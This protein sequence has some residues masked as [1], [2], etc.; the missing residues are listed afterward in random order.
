[1]LDSPQYMNADY[2]LP[3]IEALCPNPE[4][5]T[6][7][8]FLECLLLELTKE[9]SANKNL[10]EQFRIEYECL[11]TCDYEHVFESTSRS[12][13]I[14]MSQNEDLTN[15]FGKQST[16][17]NCPTC[18]G[19]KQ[20]GYLQK[21]ILKAPP[22]IIISTNPS[23]QSNQGLTLNLNKFTRHSNLPTYSLFGII[24]ARK[25]RT[26]STEATEI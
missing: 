9:S 19:D 3:I 16:F 24:R 11:L 20:N 10:F 23:V 15:F 18:A 8:N 5:Q 12:N 13:F 22:I 21:F 6:P 2:C 4:F 14:D 26:N 17:F 25:T 1:M 7:Q